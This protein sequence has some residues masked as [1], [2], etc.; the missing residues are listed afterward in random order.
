MDNFYSSVTLFEKLLQRGLPLVLLEQIQK[1]FP[2]I[3]ENKSSLKIKPSFMQKINYFVW[4]DKIR[5]KWICFLAFKIPII[6][7]RKEAYS[8]EYT[9]NMGVDKFDQN[10]LT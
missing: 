1:I 6:N 5:N 3:S 8:V 7:R 4:V 2:E 9:K 10:K